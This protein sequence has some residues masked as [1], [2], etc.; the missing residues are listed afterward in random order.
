MQAFIAKLDLDDLSNVEPSI[1]ALNAQDARLT[2]MER[3][4]AGHSDYYMKC[5][6]FVFDAKSLI[7]KSLRPSSAN[8]NEPNRAELLLLRLSRPTLKKTFRGIGAKKYGIFL[9][10]ALL[11]FFLK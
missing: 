2:C 1:M 10:H 8:L 4:R 9:S 7:H 6:P 3:G 11:V 5:P